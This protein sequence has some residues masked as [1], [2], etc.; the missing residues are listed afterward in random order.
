MRTSNLQSS[1]L[2]ESATV[3]S[4]GTAFQAEMVLRKNACL[5]TSTHAG[6]VWSVHVLKTGIGTRT[7]VKVFLVRWKFY[8]RPYCSTT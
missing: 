1:Q 5:K 3:T 4:W 7:P 8:Y 6:T 2:N